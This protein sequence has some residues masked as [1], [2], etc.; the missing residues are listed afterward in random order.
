MASLN[1]FKDK[2]RILLLD[3]VE[4][5]WRRIWPYN[6]FRWLADEQVSAFYFPQTSPV[7]IHRP[8]GMEGLVGLGRK[9]EPRTWYRVQATDPPPST[10]LHAPLIITHGL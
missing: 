4:A 8:G 2:P 6:D 1:P 5:I 3:N 7:P 10:A 9:F